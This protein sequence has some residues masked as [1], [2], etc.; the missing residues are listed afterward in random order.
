[1]KIGIVGA[2]HVGSTAA[3]SLVLQG[4]GSELVLV[5]RNRPLAEAQAM[6][7]LHATPFSHPVTIHGGD[8]AD[9][10]GCTLVI[11]AAGISQLPG[12][13]R[14]ALLQRNAAVFSDIVPR[15]VQHAPD[16]VFLVATNP[17]DVMTQIATSL[18]GLPAGRVLG[19]GTILD[20]ARFRSLLGQSFGVA[21]GSIHAYVLGEHGDS[22]VLL[23]S[24]AEVAGIQLAEFALA[25][26][27][28]LTPEVKEQID[29]NVRRAAYH[30]IDGKGATYYGIGAAL[31]RLSRCILYDERTVF[32]A[33]SVVPAI[34]DITDVALSLPHIIGRSGILSTL[35]P[36]IDEHERKALRES[37]ALIKRNVVSLGY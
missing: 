20:T 10:E 5:D 36:P 24:G 3:Y 6:D 11:L 4:I 14:I 7:I 21:P 12:E 9:L 13:T 26:G 23:W 2:G 35:Q 37:A 8:F 22:E 17:L 29:Q 27:H 34:E 19:T 30:I 25:C 15:A 16:A 31:A 18:A 32:T 1:M 28:P 33:C